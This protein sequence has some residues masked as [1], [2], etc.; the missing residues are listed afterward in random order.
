MFNPLY[1][2]ST[3]LSPLIPRNFGELLACGP[4]KTDM[5]ARFILKPNAT[6]KNIDDGSWI[7][8]IES[9]LILREGFFS[10]KLTERRRIH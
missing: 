6:S 10:P 9:S 5:V 8:L 7:E 3:L 4:L 1:T 2:V